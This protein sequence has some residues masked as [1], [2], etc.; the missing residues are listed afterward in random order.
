MLIRLELNL[1]KPFVINFALKSK[2]RR[3][4]WHGR[5]GFR[6]ELR[7]GTGLE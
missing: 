7:I 2:F 5:I 1:D 6:Y 4:I 3:S